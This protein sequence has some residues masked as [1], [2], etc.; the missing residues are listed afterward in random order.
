MD[1]I[2]SYLGF[3]QKSNNC[4]MGQTALKRTTK[5]LN[6]IL[7]CNSASNNLKDLAKNLANKHNCEMIVSKVGLGDL[8]KFQDIKILGL[9][10]ENL[11]KAILQNKEKINIG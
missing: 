3:A 2:I 8:I 9:T 6:L 4:I 7:V 1:K 10:D 11:S 5:H